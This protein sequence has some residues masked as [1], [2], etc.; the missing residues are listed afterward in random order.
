MILNSVYIDE[1][2][3]LCYN[4]STPQEKMDYLYFQ[5]RLEEILIQFEEECIDDF[6]TDKSSQ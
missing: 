1:N 2:G 6:T 3:E 5:V 4:M